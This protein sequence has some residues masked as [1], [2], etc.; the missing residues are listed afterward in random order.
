MCLGSERRGPAAAGGDVWR[1]R[2]FPIRHA[3]NAMGLPPSI[4]LAQVPRVYY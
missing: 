1:S 4:A 3:A 2:A